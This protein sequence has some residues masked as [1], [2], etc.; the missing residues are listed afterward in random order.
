MILFKASKEL[1][2]GFVYFLNLRSF[3][4]P[5]LVTWGPG[6]NTMNVIHVKDVALAMLTVLKS[7]LEGRVDS[8]SDGLCSRLLTMLLYGFLTKICCC[9]SS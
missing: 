7:A 9:R 3:P 4:G 6:S 2:P 1:L 8:G 5:P